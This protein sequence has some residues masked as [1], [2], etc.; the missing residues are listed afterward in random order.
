MT[1]CMIKQKIKNL[2][3]ES[4]GLVK[5]VEYDYDKFAFFENEI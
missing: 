1:F 4:Y 2:R 3:D 5:T